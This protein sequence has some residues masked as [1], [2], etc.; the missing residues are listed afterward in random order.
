MHL[1]ILQNQNNFWT[2]QIQAYIHTCMAYDFICKSVCNKLN[3]SKISVYYS[4]LLL[5]LQVLPTTQ[6]WKKNEQYAR[7]FVDFLG[8]FHFNVYTNNSA[9]T[10]SEARRGEKL[11]RYH[12][13]FD[14]M[15]R[16]NGSLF[17][18]SSV[19]SYL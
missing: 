10:F 14:T 3:N 4:S 8:V 16:R 12:T 6:K 15:P 7:S 19:P 13:S 17:S 2:K 1:S 18:P 9:P 11:T 5:P